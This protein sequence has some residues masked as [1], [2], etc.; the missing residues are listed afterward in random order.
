MA[1]AK[2]PKLQQWPVPQYYDDEPAEAT[3]TINGREFRRYHGVWCVRNR[4]NTWRSAGWMPNGPSV[5]DLLDHINRLPKPPPGPG[6]I[7]G[8]INLLESPCSTTS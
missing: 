5:N 3:Q 1:K 4:A 2:R 6:P 7:P 8:Q